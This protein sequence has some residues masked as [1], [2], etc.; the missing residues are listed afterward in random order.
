ME[1]D[2]LWRQTIASKYSW[3]EKIGWPS[4]RGS[5]LFKGPQSQIV[6]ILLSQNYENTVLYDDWYKTKIG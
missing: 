5:W 4:M 6:K 3:N 2:A 1:K